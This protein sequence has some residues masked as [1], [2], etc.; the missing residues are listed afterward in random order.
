[1][2]GMSD[3]L[4]AAWAIAAKDLRVEWR[5]KE[6]VYSMVFFA[7]LVVL[8]FAFAFT[9]EGLSDLNAVAGAL[10]IAVALTGTLGLNRAVDREREGNTVRALLLAPIDRNAIYLG[11]LVGITIF[12]L[13]AEACAVPILALLFQSPLFDHIFPLAVLL[14]LGTVGYSAVGSLFAAMLGRTRGR[15]VLLGILLYPIVIPIL[16][17]GTRGTQA[18]LMHPADVS[19]AW[20]WAKMILAFDVVF[21]TVALWVYEPLIGV[22]VE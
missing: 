9:R 19:M 5:A 12:I 16:L 10:W 21:V 3:F 1:M 15:D 7:A 6:I 13:L 18:L 14:V 2:L 20:F 17:A 11:K 8:L 22:A 4:G